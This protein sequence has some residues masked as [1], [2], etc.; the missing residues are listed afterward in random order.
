MSKAEEPAPASSKPSGSTP[1]SDAQNSVPRPTPGGPGGHPVVPVYGSHYAPP[2]QAPIPGVGAEGDRGAAV[3]G[4]RLGQYTILE[5]IG[6]GG[7]GSVFKAFDTALERTVALKVLFSSGLDNPKHAERFVREA[8]SLARLNHP[9]LVHVYNVGMDNDC[10]YFAMELMEG[11]S[12]SQM[13]RRRRRIPA[14]EALPILGQ[15]LSALHYI[16]RQGVTHRDVKSGNIMVAGR[17]A[18]L[19]DF[20]L[21]KDDHFT[22]L[23]SDGSVLGTP[24]YMAPEQAEGVVAGP[25]TDLYSLGVVMYEMLSGAVPFVGKSA[26][27]IIR[28]HLEVPPPPIEAALPNIDPLLASCV[29]KCLS[30][31]A[32]DRYPNCGAL[33]ADLVKLQSTS[34]LAT[35]VEETASEEPRTVPRTGPVLPTATLPFGTQPTAIEARS[36]SEITRNPGEQ[37]ATLTLGAAAVRVNQS[38]ELTVPETEAAL[39]AAVPAPEAHTTRPW[40]WVALGF[41]GVILLAI[42]LAKRHEANQAAKQPDAHGTPARVHR[43]G[44]KAEDIRLIEFRTGGTDPSQWML[45]FERQSPDGTWVRESANYKDAERDSVLLEFLAQNPG[46]V[47][48]RPR[49]QGKAP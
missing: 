5:K 2:G 39:A 35:L 15:I 12:L 1:P 31:K 49:T 28:Q 43:P 34:E 13:I 24:D 30:K 21:A 6:Q 36:M 19:M 14:Q 41:F 27:T 8:R 44:A 40:L 38:S 17:R 33:A 22:G 18:V 11:E 16:H 4:R 9:N 23:T 47:P 45:V 42:F 48:D 46:V 37:D 3:A 29:H 20:G 32:L 25:P 26:L 7:M 10:Y